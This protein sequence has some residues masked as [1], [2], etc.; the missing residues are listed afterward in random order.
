MDSNLESV[1]DEHVRPF[2]NSHGGDLEVL[3]YK[4][5]IVK[6]KM[7]GSCAGCPSA[8]FTNEEVVKSSLMQQIPGLKDVI[9]VNDV[10]DRLMEQA[11][12]IMRQRNKN[13]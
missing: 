10:S 6:F 11:R 4:D 2:L 3:E 5:D 13:N 7:T 12:E 1:L 9:L 8:D